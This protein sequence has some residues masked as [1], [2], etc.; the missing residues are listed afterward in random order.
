MNV[1]WV[2]QQ[3]VLLLFSELLVVVTQRGDRQ[4]WVKKI[5][6]GKLSFKSLIMQDF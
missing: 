5:K 6:R 1:E 4:K 3:S 2:Q